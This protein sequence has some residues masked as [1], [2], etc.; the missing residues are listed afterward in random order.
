MELTVQALKVATPYEGPIDEK[1]IQKAIE[2][3]LGNIEQGL[4]YVDSF[5]QIGT[6][7]IDT[8]AIDDEDNAVLIEYKRPGDFSRDA[9][10]QLMN[11]YSWFASDQ[12]HMTFLRDLARKVKPPLNEITDVRLMEVVSDYD[13]DVRNACWALKPPIKLISYKLFTDTAKELTVLPFTILDT[14]VGGQTVVRPP[15]T[16]DD[17]LRD[18]DSLRTLYHELKAKVTAA[19]GSDAK[20]NPAPQDYIGLARRRNFCS[21]H[22]KDKWIR[23]DLLLKSSEIGGSARYKDYPASEWGYMHISSSK[24][25]DE[26]FLS[27]VKK[28][29]E[30]AA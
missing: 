14:E 2:A 16:E 4:V 7:I 21:F 12:N 20:I 11:Y 24:D 1:Q 8:V 23:V 30:K 18:H 22:F 6:G 15:K 25:I 17:H 10:I 13:E 5:V 3:N 26:E 9:L 28:A 19:T 27:W 29:Y